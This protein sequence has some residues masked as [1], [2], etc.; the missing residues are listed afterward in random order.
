MTPSGPGNAPATS[1]SSTVASPLSC[2][3]IGNGKVRHVGDVFVD[4]VDRHGI[5]KEV[6]VLET[7][8]NQYFDTPY[9]EVSDARPANEDESQLPLCK[10]CMRS[11]KGR[12]WALEDDD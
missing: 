5:D 2:Y 8:C 6:E 12:Q 1:G 10:A 4:V 11:L 7:W 3:V 9:N